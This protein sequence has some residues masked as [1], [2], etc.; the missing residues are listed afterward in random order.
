[1]FVWE[2]SARCSIVLWCG[3]VCAG[4]I[5]YEVKDEAIRRAFEPFGPIRNLAMS[6]DPT[7]QRHKG[8]AFLEYEVPEA[9]ILAIDS[10]QTAQVAGRQLKV[11]HF[12]LPPLHCF[13]FLLPRGLGT[14]P[15]EPCKSDDRPLTE[16]DLQVGRPSNLPQAQPILDE[17]IQEGAPYT[18]VYVSSI[19]P[20]LAEPDLRR[21]ASKL[22]NSSSLYLITTFFPQKFILRF[23][24]LIFLTELC[25]E[26]S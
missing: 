18:R 6:Y 4:S 17:I 26:R 11:C 13:D 25:L 20:D 16:A 1:M 22:F 10:M 5:N 23:S 24:L 21:Y 8:F 14:K 7:T 2:G 15:G 9:A 12:R 3:V 19:H